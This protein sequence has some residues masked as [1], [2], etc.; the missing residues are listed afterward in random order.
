MCNRKKGHHDAASVFA[1]VTV[2][3][4]TFATPNAL[5]GAAGLLPAAAINSFSFA[6]GPACA[7]RLQPAL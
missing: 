7:I 4:S 5:V 3:S 1:A 6:A 2:A